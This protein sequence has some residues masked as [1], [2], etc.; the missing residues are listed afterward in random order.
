LKTINLPKISIR[1]VLVTFLFFQNAYSQKKGNFVPT[2]SC[3]DV[4]I[5]I[6]EKYSVGNKL[7]VP[8]KKVTQ[9]LLTNA[10]LSVVTDETNCLTLTIKATGKQKGA[11]YTTRNGTRYIRSGGKLSG[12]ISL[13]YKG[14]QIRKLKFKANKNPPGKTSGGLPFRYLINFPGSF[15][16]KLIDLMWEIYG[17]EW[18]RNCLMDT[19]I[20]LYKEVPIRRFLLEKT[21]SRIYDIMLEILEH[22]S[23]PSKYQIIDYVGQHNIIKAVPYMIDIIENTALENR[24]K[25][26]FRSSMSVLVK[27]QDR[28][29][30][31]I[32]INIIKTAGNPTSRDNYFRSAVDVLGHLGDPQAIEVLISIL[33]LKYHRLFRFSASKALEKITGLNFGMDHEKWISWYEI[34][35]QSR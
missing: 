25:T 14:K 35:N 3:K 4:K 16:P 27:L 23:V 12:T 18:Y 26:I 8:F 15:L 10:G 22:S 34:N 7:N 11:K 2:T 20:N 24:N 32:M 5:V 28:Q 13:Y 29:A 19:T 31:P 17:V 30:V 9:M 6:E 33:D 1:L 21:D